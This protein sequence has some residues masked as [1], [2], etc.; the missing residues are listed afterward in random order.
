MTKLR[1]TLALQLLFFVGW[2][3]Y[4]LYSRDSGSG[5]FYLE[6]V[7]VDPRDLISGTYVAL[8]YDVSRPSLGGCP[9]LNE[10]GPIYV[11][12]Q[13]SGRT[14]KLESGE[15]EVYGAFDCSENPPKEPGW[16]KADLQQVFGGK[17]AVYGIE[18]FFLNEKDPRKD[19]RSG[20]VAAKVRIGRNGKLQLLDLIKKL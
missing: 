17:R 15:T 18:K 6:T 8:N 14:I 1:I 16:V 3:G 7:P 10:P 13:P 20:S 19:A 2:G 12:L 11:N 5:D 4:L 9:A